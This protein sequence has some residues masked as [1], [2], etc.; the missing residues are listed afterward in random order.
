LPDTKTPSIVED[1]SPDWVEY[2]FKPV[3]V[4]LVKRKP[5]QWWPVVVGDA[6]KCDSELPPPS[7][8]TL[9]RVEYQ[10]GDWNQC[11]FKATASAL[12]YCGWQ[13]VASCI[14]STAPS[15]QYLPREEAIFALRK[16]MIIHVPEIGG[17]IAF[18]QHQKRRKMNRLSLDELVQNKTRFPTVVIPHANDGSASHAVVVVDDIIFDATQSHAMKLCKGSFDWICGKGG[19]GAIER[20]LRFEMP[21]QTKKRYARTMTK[22][23]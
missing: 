19:I 9:I 23:W 14:S 11:L 6:R 13:K 5:R 15:V 21:H 20:A 17:V 1:L 3:F 10:Q 12:H 4:E 2:V 18:N 8:T 22:N 7:L 16:S